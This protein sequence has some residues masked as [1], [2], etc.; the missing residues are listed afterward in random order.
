MAP[1]KSDSHYDANGNF[2]K[3]FKRSRV[4]DFLYLLPIKYKKHNPNWV[5]LNWGDDYWARVITFMSLTSDD[6]YGT[7]NERYRA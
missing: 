7:T 3:D 2:I 4:I 1:S 5:K 6:P